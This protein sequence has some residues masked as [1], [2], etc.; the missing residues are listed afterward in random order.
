MVE[1]WQ[2]EPGGQQTEEELMAVE[3]QLEPKR[4]CDTKAKAEPWG[5]VDEVKPGGRR[6]EVEPESEGGAR[7]S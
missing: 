6:T 5:R 1:F 2:A 7:L 3:T 4:P